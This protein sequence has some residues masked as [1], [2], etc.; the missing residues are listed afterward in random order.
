MASP[1]PD[2]RPDPPEDSREPRVIEVAGPEAHTT[3]EAL[4]AETSHTIYAE[5]CQE[6]ATPS[7]LQDRTG[8]SLQ[9]L[10]YHLEKLENA[11]LIEAAGSRYSDRGREMTVYAPRHDPL[12][13]TGDPESR[14]SL[15][16]EL[17]RIL[18]T[19]AVV[20]GLGL[21]G[22]W[23]AYASGLLEGPATTVGPAGTAGTGFS[24]TVLLFEPAVLIFLGALL[25]GLIYLVAGRG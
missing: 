7:D 2:L 4:S 13:F 15:T 16:T 14:R 18:S 25:A 10:S 9:N 12:V 22:Q 20:A 17:P 21:L 1:L 23:A 6:P 24:P 19:V 5:L 8:V 11:G 3:F